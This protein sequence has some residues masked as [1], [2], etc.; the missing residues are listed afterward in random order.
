MSSLGVF[1]F[2]SL[3]ISHGYS[4][5]RAPSRGEL[6]SPLRG[7]TSTLAALWRS[8]SAS[9]PAASRGKL[10][11]RPL[12]LSLGYC[13][14]LITLMCLVLYRYLYKLTVVS[15]HTNCVYFENDYLCYRHDQRSMVNPPLK[16]NPRIRVS[17]T[18]YSNHVCP[19]RYML[20]A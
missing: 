9:I 18:L 6:A 7:A 4:P 12:I 11:H 20:R 14:L 10:S 13:L 15:G 2:S 5:P 3:P 19:L 1:L 17:N 8:R 16:S